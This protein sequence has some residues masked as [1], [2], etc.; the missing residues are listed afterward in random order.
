MAV[1]ASAQQTIIDITDA[2]TVYL[3][4]PSWTFAGTTGAAKPG[5]AKTQVKALRGPDTVPVAVDVDNAVKAEGVTVE[6][7]GDATSPTITIS[8][9]A[10]V[11]A[12]GK[13][14][15]PVTVAGEAQFTLDFTYG[16]AYTGATGQP[17]K[18]GTP[19]QP[20]ANGQSTFFHIAWATS[21]DGSQGF[22]TSDPTGKTY[23]GTYVDGN[24]ADSED[25]TKYEWALF[26]G[27]DGTNG[28]DGEQGI[29]GKNG[30]DGKTQYLHI[31]Y[32]TSADGSQGFD[33]VN[34]SGKTYIGQYVDFVADDTDDPTKY[35]WTKIKGDQ[36][37]QGNPGQDG[38]PG[39]DAISMVIASSAG[40]IFKNSKIDTTLTAHVYK[41]GVEVTG[42]ALAALGTIKW[43]KDGGTDAV[44]TGASIHVTAESV[45]TTATY[46]AQLEG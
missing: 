11:T 12:P 40:T 32:A 31:A 19:G 6:S 33:K 21:A 5:S 7:D 22:S 41:G 2:Y 20:G 36:G 9:N 17:G 26:K 23:I 16:I 29:P 43:Y 3:T 46:V 28:K 39:A 45:N 14:S 27:A 10:S 15:L 13:V 30:A 37:N 4:C 38:R 8:V 42:D 24:A 44:G 35:A 1:K 25:P 18:D 34:S